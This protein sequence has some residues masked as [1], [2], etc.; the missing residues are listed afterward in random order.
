[1]ADFYKLGMENIDVTFEI[2]RQYP[3]GIMVLETKFDDEYRQVRIPFVFLHN[4][5]LF[6]WS[7]FYSNYVLQISTGT[8]LTRTEK[9]YFSYLDEYCFGEALILEILRKLQKEAA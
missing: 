5:C 7:K 8:Y 6:K 4:E 3:N 1:M 9:E 2:V